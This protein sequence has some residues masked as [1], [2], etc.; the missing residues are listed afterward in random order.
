MY[1]DV[2]TASALALESIQTADNT[3]YININDYQPLIMMTSRVGS[4]FPCHFYSTN[5]ITIS[6][7]PELWIYI[8]LSIVNIKLLINES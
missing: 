4:L 6:I 5:M 2:L 1:E 3:M 8:H 7:L